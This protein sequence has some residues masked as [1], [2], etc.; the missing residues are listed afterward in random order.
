MS[1]TESADPRLDFIYGE[2]VRGLMQQAAA[3]ESLRSRAGTLIFAASF[4]SS[5]LGGQALADGLGAWDLAALALLLGIGLSCVALLWPYYDFRFR[6]DARQLLE[7][8]VDG[9]TRGGLDEMRRELALEIEADRTSNGRLI[10]RMREA[11]QLGLVL[12]I[13]ELLTWSISIAAAG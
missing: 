7:R 13:A 11:L 3:V 9:P 5:L 4:A 10:R 6:F 1:P 12:L 2:A 8:F